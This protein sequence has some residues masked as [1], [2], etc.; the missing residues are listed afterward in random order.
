MVWFA[1]TL[2]CLVWHKFTAAARALIDQPNMTALEIAKKAMNIA[3][4]MCRIIIITDYTGFHHSRGV[5]RI[6]LI[7]T[8]CVLL[9]GVYTNKNFVI[10]IIESSSDSPAASPSQ[11]PSNQID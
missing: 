8:A 10:E 5:F 3:S 6:I 4:D 11:T 7:T 1:R 2:I 9:T